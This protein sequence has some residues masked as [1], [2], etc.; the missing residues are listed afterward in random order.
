M[1]QSSARAEDGVAERTTINETLLTV[2]ERVLPVDHRNRMNANLFLRRGKIR[3]EGV[4]H[5]IQKNSSL[6][7][8]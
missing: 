2:A 6:T 1:I 3:N 7:L 8:N 5:R 4:N